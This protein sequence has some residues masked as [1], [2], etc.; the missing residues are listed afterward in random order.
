MAGIY[1]HIPF[2]KQACT[3]CDFHFS[4]NMNSKP[5][6]VK[7]ILLEIDQRKNYIE[8]EEIETIY[9]GGGTPS[10]LDEHELNS[11]LEKINKEFKVAINAEITLECN[12]DDLTPQKLEQL[13]KAGI[14]RLSIGLQSFNEEELK[15]MNRAHT[16][17]ESLSCV[18]L[19]QSK[20]FDNITIDLIYGSKFQDQQSWEGTLQTVVNLNVQHISAYN[21]TIESKTKLGVDHKKG[22][23]PEVSEEL[24]SEQFKKMIEVLQKNGFVHYEISNFGKENFFSKHNSNYWKGAKYLGLGPSAHSFNTQSRQWNISSNSAYIKKV[25]SAETYFELE[26]LTDAEHYNEYILTR[27]RTIWGCDTKEIEQRFGK[28]MLNSFEETVKKH[29]KYFNSTDGIIT[30]NTE[31]KLRADFLAVSFPLE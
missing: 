18:K 12:P 1:L 28:V 6:L 3:Y 25:N 14:N 29:Q 13:K 9:F 10:V 15:W 27:L 24:S 30:L 21:L 23:E 8:G 7:A 20:G 31:G 22:S 16:A 17:A 11:I 4:V 2:C 19:A 5:E 26:T